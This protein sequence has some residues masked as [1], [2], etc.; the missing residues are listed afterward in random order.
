LSS[1]AGTGA[2]GAY[3]DRKFPIS[4]LPSVEVEVFWSLRCFRSERWNFRLRRA[5]PKF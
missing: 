5:G 4:S 3:I 1:V 2:K